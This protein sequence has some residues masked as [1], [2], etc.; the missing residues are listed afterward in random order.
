MDV[1]VSTLRAELR[2]WIERAGAGEEI[3]ITERGIPVARLTGVDASDVLT[4]LER[5]GLIAAPEAHTRP[6]ARD[7]PRAEPATGRAAMSELFRRFRR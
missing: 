4:E 1:P 3:I 5:D 6:K 7:V 2:S